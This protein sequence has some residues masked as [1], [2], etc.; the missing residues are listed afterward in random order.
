MNEKE[1]EGAP[2]DQ[3]PIWEVTQNKYGDWELFYYCSDHMVAY[4]KCTDFPYEYR[5][6][7]L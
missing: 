7:Q 4:I 1:C 5:R 6:L 2:C 3:P